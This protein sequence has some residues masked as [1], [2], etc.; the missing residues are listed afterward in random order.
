MSVSSISSVSAP[1]TYPYP[2]PNAAKVPDVKTDSDT[3]D[4]TT[5]QPPPQAPLPPGQGTRVNQLA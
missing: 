5:T 1:P 4:A 3:N 2:D